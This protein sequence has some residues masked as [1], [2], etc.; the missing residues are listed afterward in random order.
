MARTA[1]GESLISISHLLFLSLSVHKPILAAEKAFII[2]LGERRLQPLP[3]AA[4][5]PSTA[6]C[7]IARFRWKMFSF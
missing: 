6:N 2:I 1:P 3:D 5:P 4:A 7:L